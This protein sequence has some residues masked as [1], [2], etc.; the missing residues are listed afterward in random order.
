MFGNNAF[1]QSANS[2]ILTGLQFWGDCSDVSSIT[3]DGSNLVSQLNDKSGL[4][5]HVTAVGG[6]RPLYVAN[7]QNGKSIIRFDGVD[8]VL[9]R[10]VLFSGGDFTYFI[11]YKYLTYVNLSRTPL[12]NGNASSGFSYRVTTNR[13][14]VNN[15]VAAIANGARSSVFE[16]VSVF[17]ESLTPNLQFFLNNIN[18]NIGGSTTGYVAATGGFTLGS[19]TTTSEF[20]NFELGEVLVYNRALTRSEMTQNHKYLLQKWRF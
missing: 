9:S 3:K 20:A 11:A 10:A 5:N 13:F 16:T 4:A 7:I 1:F 12:V 19:R 6:A 2:P 17:R 15:S 14:H 8:D 18:Q